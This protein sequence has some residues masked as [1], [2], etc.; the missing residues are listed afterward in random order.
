MPGGLNLVSRLFR[1]PLSIW[2]AECFEKPFVTIKTTLGERHLINDPAAIE[3]VLVTNAANYDRDP[4]QKAILQRT[5]GGS[6]FTAG[7][8][9]WRTLRKAV[10]PFFASRAMPGYSLRIHQAADA[11]IERW[12]LSQ[13]AA[14][15]RLDE[16]MMAITLSVINDVLFNGLIRDDMKAVA[17]NVRRYAAT[18]GRVDLL[19]L[20]HAPA[21]MPRLRGLAGLPHARAVRQR[22]R[23]LLASREALGSHPEG[24]DLIGALLAARDDAGLPL[25]RGLI[26]DTLAVLIGTGSDTTSIALTWSL[27]LLSQSPEMLH[28]VEAECT[29]ALAG[30]GP[31]EVNKLVRTRS[32]IDEALRLYPPAP[33][34]GRQARAAD[35]L[36]S[37]P[38]QAGSEVII[39]PWIVHRHALHWQEPNVFRPERFLPGARGL[40]RSGIYLPFGAGP[41]ICLG[42]AFGLHEAAIILACIMGKVRLEPLRFSD[43]KLTH[44]LTLQIVGGAPC[45]VRE[46]NA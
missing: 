45:R 17:V 21:W 1:N 5:T 18:R 9:L 2:S 32:V 37:L 11:A 40:I 10:A 38:L 39:A 8:A 4:V 42:M 26:E 12:L 6:F 36:G 27:L 46:R 20:V 15:I 7:P 30:H 19:D 25:N 33:L 29:R 16:I 23:T 28:T 35:Q 43:L 22:S 41:H 13:R 34:I 24:P 31:I 3:H 14:V 44:D